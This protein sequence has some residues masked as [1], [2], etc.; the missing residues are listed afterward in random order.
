MVYVIADF[1]DLLREG[2]VELVFE[3]GTTDGEGPWGGFFHF[4]EAL[5]AVDAACQAYWGG[6]VLDQCLVEGY[7]IACVA[8]AEEVD[9]IGTFFDAG[10]GFCY[11][12][13]DSA[14]EH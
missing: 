4:V 2:S 14:F 13:V 3:E 10:F 12:F 11:H 9:A 1:V 8:I 7:C 6:Y 5:V